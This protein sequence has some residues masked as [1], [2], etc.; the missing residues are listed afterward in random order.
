MSD[1]QTLQEWAGAG[2]SKM[3]IALVFTDIVGST[4]LLRKLGDDRWI[5]MLME[6]FYR[7]R[8]HIDVNYGHEIKLIGD[9]VMAAFRS[10]DDALNF[11]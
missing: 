8:A 9:S 4:E 5:E 3:T 7:A 2:V 1:K 10:A 11:A 6:H